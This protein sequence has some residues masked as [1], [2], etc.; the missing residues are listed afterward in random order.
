[1]FQSQGKLLQSLQKVRPT[2]YTNRM[3]LALSTTQLSPVAEIASAWKSFINGGKT[4]SFLNSIIETRVALESNGIVEEFS[5]IATKAVRLIANDENIPNAKTKI[6]LGCFAAMKCVQFK[7]D[8]KGVV[9]RMVSCVISAGIDQIEPSNEVRTAYYYILI[10]ENDSKQLLEHHYRGFP[11]IISLQ[12]RT[13][14]Y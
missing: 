13:I 1:M 14:L 6:I 8:A 10:D 11:F 12:G 2:N 5:D 4:F 9:E 3:S 7:P